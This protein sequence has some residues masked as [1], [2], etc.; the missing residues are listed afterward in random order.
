MPIRSNLAE[1]N[2]IVQRHKLK[3]NKSYFTQPTVIW[4]R[5]GRKILRWI[6][7][8][9]IIQ[10]GEMVMLAGN[11]RFDVINEPDELGV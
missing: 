3:L 10:A 9:K 1:K 4:V 2:T 6:N 11:Q 5:R 8:E 7:G